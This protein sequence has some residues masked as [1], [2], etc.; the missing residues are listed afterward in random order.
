MLVSVIWDGVILLFAK[1]S[2]DLLYLDIALLS[3]C[4]LVFGIITLSSSIRCE[5]HVTSCIFGYQFYLPQKFGSASIW[6]CCKNWDQHLGGY[7][8]IL[9]NIAGSSMPISS[10]LNYWISNLRNGFE[11]FCVTKSFPN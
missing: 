1:N 6:L 4:L 11:N 5:I 3:S 7:Y 8:L 9:K 10:S 2:C